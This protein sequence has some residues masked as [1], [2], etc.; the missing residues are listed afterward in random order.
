M[1]QTI[2][3]LQKGWRQRKL[4]ILEARMGIHSGPVVAGNVGSRER[5][6]YTVLGDTV[7]LASRLEG[8]NKLYG[9]TILI[10][11]DTFQL[12]GAGFVTRELDSIRVKG[13]QAPV[14]IYELIGKHGEVEL[15]FLDIFAEGLAEYKN[16]QWDRAERHFRSIA[17][18]DRPSRTYLEGVSSIEPIRPRRIGM[19]YLSTR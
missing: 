1:Q 19:E 15:P 6:N 11:E 10:S 4:P 7:N 13:R 9:T 2:T 12:A 16:W 18:M 17:S 8:A 5:F 3:M 14:R